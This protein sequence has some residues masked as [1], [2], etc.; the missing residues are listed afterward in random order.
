M[1]LYSIEWVKSEHG[2]WR[3]REC[4]EQRYRH[5]NIQV[6]SEVSNDIVSRQKKV[7]KEKKS[8]KGLWDQSSA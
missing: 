1:G 2:K 4:S 5:S 6:S 7:R 8:G 3:K